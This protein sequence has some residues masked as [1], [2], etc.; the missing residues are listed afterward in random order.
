M[1]TSLNPCCVELTITWLSLPALIT[2][3]PVRNQGSPGQTY[4]WLIAV[5]L[6][7]AE[8][9][10][11][12]GVGEERKGRKVQ[13]ASPAGDFKLHQKLVIPHT[14]AAWPEVWGTGFKVPSEEV[15]LACTLKFPRCLSPLSG[16]K[17]QRNFKNH[18]C[19]SAVIMLF[20]TPCVLGPMEW[21]MKS[22][23]KQAWDQRN[24][25]WCHP[26]GAFPHPDTSTSRNWVGVPGPEPE[27]Q[28]SSTAQ[29]GGQLCPRPCGCPIQD[30]DVQ[31]SIR[32]CHGSAP[33]CHMSSL[34]HDTNKQKMC[35]KRCYT[36]YVKYLC[37]VS[38]ILSC[39]KL[40]L[41]GGW[42]TIYGMI[43]TLKCIWTVMCARAWKET[44][45]FSV[46]SFPNIH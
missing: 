24:I 31:L 23:E 28:Y 18:S 33:T 5:T 41:M 13:K 26:H 2:P 14:V 4:N 35:N 38:A 36:L 42:A 43:N 37:G 17:C 3:G 8:Q 11:L 25:S 40:T 45:Y 10:L 15:A 1:G 6:H 32:I 12:A 46:F 27:T 16:S 20:K 7:L 21:S 30:R 19:S 44:I 29:V 22:R 39:H 34:S 9:R